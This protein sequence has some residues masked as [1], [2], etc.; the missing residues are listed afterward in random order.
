MGVGA[1]E[2]ELEAMERVVLDTTQVAMEHDIGPL[3][4]GL[5]GEWTSNISYQNSRIIYEKGACII[6]M[7]EG[8]LTE[9]TL[10]RAF[11]TYVER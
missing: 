1:V 9:G 8:I 3:T 5:R 11:Q 6:R 7:M 4:H 2:P 10:Q